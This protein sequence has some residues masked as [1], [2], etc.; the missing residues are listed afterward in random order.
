MFDFTVGYESSITNVA[1]PLELKAD[2]VLQ[3]RTAALPSAGVK[4][5]SYQY[6][7]LCAA[8]V[9]DVAANMN[10]ITRSIR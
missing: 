9:A 1:E 3:T 6:F 10:G 4:A 2:G 8:K 7:A 5:L